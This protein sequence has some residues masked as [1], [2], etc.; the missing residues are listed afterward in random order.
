MGG[1]EAFDAALDGAHGFVPTGFAG[2]VMDVSVHVVS[3]GALFFGVI[4]DA[5]AFEFAVLD[6]VHEFVEV[7]I[8]LTGEADDEGGADGDA[9]DASADAFEKVANVSTIGLTAHEGEHVVADML[10][11]HID[12]AGDFW[13]FGD[14]LDEVV[15]PVGGMGVEQ[16]D[17]E[18]AF[19]FV[20]SA[21]KGREGFA[22]GG[23]YAAAGFGAV[24]GPF[25]HAEVGGILGDEIDFFDAGG[26]EVACLFDDAVLRTAAVAATDL[27][28]DAEGAGV[29]AAFGD[30]DVGEVVWGEAEAGGIVVGDVFGLAGDE[31]F[32]LGGAHEALDNGGDAGDLI[33]AD[34]GIDV[35]HEVGQ[36]LGKTL[37]K[38]AGDDDFLFLA[39]FAAFFTCI[40]GVVDRSDA[41]LF[42]HVDE[43]AG[44]DDEDVG[45]FGFRGHGHSGLLEV[46]DHDF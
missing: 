4:E 35:G 27:R 43:R 20:E 6:E 16:A 13:A 17:P 21:D 39:F 33:E 15:A 24:F 2:H 5:S 18:V 1:V 30:F 8:G 14:G 36:F 19:D 46:T 10:E 45:E 11:R 32:L 9:G 7:G 26:D 28:D 38:A 44:I 12:V 42:R 40:D 37:R 31:V 29:V 25:I 22:L 34:E 3:A 41:F 23:V